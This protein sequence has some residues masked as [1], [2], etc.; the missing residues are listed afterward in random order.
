MKDFKKYFSANS[1]IMLLIDV[2]NGNIADANSAAQKFYGYSHKKMLSLNIA[3]L[4]VLPK[5]EIRKQIVAFNSKKIIHKFFRHKTADKTIKDIQVFVSPIQMDGKKFNFAIIQDVTELKIKEKENNRFS[6]IIENAIPFIGIANAKREVFYF[7][8]SMRKAFAVPK[9][10]D[11]S[12]YKVFDF[13][14][15]KGK[16]IIKKAFSE[17][18][19]NGFWKG[20]NEM[21]SLNGKIYQ[22]I[23][24]IVLIKDEQ[25][26]PQYTS[27]VAIDITQQK[28]AEQKISNTATRYKTLLDT[29]S[30]GIH[31]INSKLKVVEANDAFCKMLGYSNREILQLSIPDWDVQWKR[32]E[33]QQRLNGLINKS[34]IFETRHKRKDGTVIDVEINATGIIIDGENYLYASSRDISERKIAEEK[35]KLSESKFRAS[36]DN[37]FDAIGVH[38]NGIWEICNPSA[39]KLFGYSKSDELI[40]KPILNVIVPEEHER[41]KNFVR[42]RTENKNAP[43]SYITRGLKKGGEIFDL[44]VSLSNFF[45]NNQLHVIVTL[46]DITERKKLENTVQHSLEKLKKIASRVPGVVYQY[47][48]E[49]DGTQSFPYVSES[50]K[51]LFGISPEEIKKDPSKIFKRIYKDDLQYINITIKRSTRNLTPWNDEFRV[52]LDNGTIRWLLGNAVPQKEADGSIL[53]YGFITD[54]TQRKKHETE[55]KQS[56]E[57]Y[58]D[59]SKLMD[60]VFENVPGL[61]FLK[62]KKNA[63]IKVNK[64]VADGY[65]KQMTELEG[66]SLSELYPEKIAQQFYRDDLDVINSGVAKLNIEENWPTKDGTKWLNTNK[67]P[68]RN[69]KGEITGV[70]G[71]SMDI[72]ERRQLEISLKQSEDNLKQGELLGKFG[73]W[74]VNLDTQV[75]QFSPG[76]SKIYGIEEAEIPWTSIKNLRLPEYDTLMDEAMYGLINKNKKYNLEYRI[77]RKSDNKIIGIHII[78]R[79]SKKDR[80]IF[81]SVQDVTERMNAEQALKISEEKFRHLITDLTI[82]VVVHSP[83]GEILFNNQKALSL[84]GLTNKQLIGKTPLDPQ[85]K[86]IH[87]DGSDFPGNTHPA[88]EA[89]KTKKIIKDVIMGV[90]RPHKKDRI[91]LMVNAMPELAIDGSVHQVIVTF[92]DLSELRKKDEEVHRLNKELKELAAH[93]QRLRADERNKLAK[94]VHDKLAQRLVGMK[95]QIEFLNDCIK[96]DI[97]EHSNKIALISG[98]I[99]DMLKDFGS[100]YKEVNPTLID[101]LEIYDAIDSLIID[102]RKRNNQ[103]TDFLSNTENEVLPHNIKW[104]LYKTVEECLDNALM[105]ANA[106]NI[107]VKLFKHGNSLNLEI[108]D[109]GKGFDISTLDFKDQIGIIEMRENVKSIGGKIIID[110]KPGYGTAIKVTVSI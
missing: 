40:G 60:T 5:N 89:I 9:N 10:A 37:S 84:L 48:V 24:T 63:F 61:L 45:Q 98:E 91:W 2:E 39:V 87:E 79:Y 65:G 56:E 14:T 88:S 80:V 92:Y 21:Q 17:I 54:I 110:S 108:I 90:Y 68:F 55:I 23:Q 74:K 83:S 29:A 86:V 73:Y 59:L 97:P 4:N 46:R 50:L 32:K 3:A 27:S 82:G 22:V 77:K 42:A 44:E 76:A 51:Y 52:T 106:N 49:T 16:K 103:H 41:I 78:S 12:K 20:E 15:D 99:S 58:R 72:S 36:L 100:I 1:A 19:K 66:K 96:K 104:I 47:R 69:T 53:W 28:Q 25:G 11:L 75:F 64:Y 95:F 18:Q 85:W 109:D 101:D 107:S 7:N 34:A 31:V 81:G 6:R 43:S 8:Q 71:M 30:D 13:Y 35:I 67:I 33:L 105:H 94:E 57:K 93:L 38:I 62:D 102:F 70:L 26:N